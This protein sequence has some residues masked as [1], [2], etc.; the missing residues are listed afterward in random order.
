MLPYPFTVLF[1][2]FNP[3]NPAYFRFILVDT[4]IYDSQKNE[5][6]LNYVMRSAFR[7]K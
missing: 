2:P 5:K 1:N 6:T 3:F 4:T 7:K